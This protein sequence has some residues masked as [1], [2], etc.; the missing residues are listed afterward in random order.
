MKLN[1]FLIR[2]GAVTLLTLSSGQALAY[3]YWTDCGN[4]TPR[5][6]GSN[7]FTFNAN[8]TGF[9]G[10][11]A[12]WFTS[13]SNA[14]ARFNDTPVNL[15]VGL[16]LDND[17]NVGVGNGE[18]EVWWG[19]NGN[20]AI[21]YNITDPC[22]NT[23]E[24]DIIFHNTVS[25]N[26]GMEDKTNFWN[27]GGDARTFETTALHEVG[28]TIGLAHENRYYN[29]MGSDYTHVHTTGDNALRSYMGE[30]AV[31]GLIATYGQTARE[32]LS[33]AAWRHTGASGEYSSHGRTRL[34]DSNGAVLDST[35]AVSGCGYSSCERR[36]E[37]EPGQAIQYEM[38]LENNGTNSHTA[39]LGYYIS[40]NAT[41]TSTDTLISTDTVTVTRNT[42]DTITRNVVIPDNLSANT[43][44]YLGVIIDNDNS[45][46]EWTEAN[47][48]SYIHMRTG[49]GSS[50]QPPVAKANGP[51][52][53]S[54]NNPVAFSSS[55]SNDPDGSIASYS[56][57]FGDGN[58]STAANPSHSYT[59]TGSYSVILT[60]TDNSGLTAN[61]T[62]SVTVSAGSLSYCSAQGGGNYEWI[63]NVATG[64]LNNSSNQAVYTDFTSQ[65]AS[66]STGNNSVTL[67]P[68][69]SGNAYTE[70]WSVWIDLNKDGDFTDS[71]EQVLSGVSGSAAVNANL[72]IPASASGV[73]GT[74]MR[75]AMKYNSAP[76]ASCGNIGD[77]E[78]EDYSVNIVADGSNQPPVAN[79]NGPYSGNMATNIAFSSAGSSDSDGSIATYSWSFGDGNS[80]SSAN[81]THS[82]S[83]AGSYTAEL[84]VTDND[85][86]SSSDSATVSVTEVSGNGLE[87]ACAT[88]TPQ[89]ANG[90]TSADAVCVPD[91]S[92]SGNI[93]YY[94]ILVPSG[95]NAIQIEAGHGSGNGNVYYKASI[96]ATA[97]NY[98]QS[99]TGTGNTENMTVNNPGSGYQYVSVVGA[100][101][102][103]TLKATLR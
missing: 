93:Q 77:G 33:V 87:D 53:G 85:G 41:I 8:P 97:S 61:D 101:T 92:D 35:V 12:K 45:V 13:F 40:T 55:G 25:Y 7:S 71:G 89:T 60:V 14:L 78:V 96:W 58:T 64:G 32:D 86:A 10:Q 16:Q 11:Y 65:T 39:T 100:R 19:N 38:T 56:W 46:S 31:N 1:Q 84:T 4:S 24:G 17:L 103:M 66:L 48:S 20:S 102:G 43:D 68:G 54:V 99:S 69:F 95:T 3:K 62:A 73:I 42:P 63:A 98:D 94:W 5:K 81:P 52:T 9:D 59:T 37:V 27:Y 76:T 50:G 34:F 91:A 30:D 67:T 74:R 26:D 18:S 57:N 22:G 49:S 70:H 28:H 75:I 82:Y 36:Y 15:T 44:Y 88:E 2:L 83:S 51:Y 79:A 80:S 90:L 47:N 21:G 6:W 29:I 72:N 23:I